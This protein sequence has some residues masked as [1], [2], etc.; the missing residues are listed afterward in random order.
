MALQHT[1]LQHTGNRML[2]TALQHTGNRMLFYIV[3]LWPQDMNSEIWIPKSRTQTH[4]R[5]FSKS[6]MEASK[7]SK[8][9]DILV[10][11]VHWALTI[12]CRIM[13]LPTPWWY[14]HC[15]ILF[16]EVNLLHKPCVIIQLWSCTYGLWIVGR[17]ARCPLTT[18]RGYRLCQI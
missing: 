3:L 18:I 17:V 1:G 4:Y 16:V 11:F 15:R 5:M 6:R 8:Q 9:S 14:K 2:Y 12:T 10:V 7:E 13:K